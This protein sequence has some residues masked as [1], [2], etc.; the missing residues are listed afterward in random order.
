MTRMA[1]HDTK[2]QFIKQHINKKTTTGGLEFTVYISILWGATFSSITYHEIL[3]FLY[4]F[5]HL[6]PCYYLALW[7]YPTRPACLFSSIKIC[8]HTAQ[9]NIFPPWNIHQL[10]GQHYF[11]LE[12]SQLPNFRN[13]FSWTYQ[14]PEYGRV[15]TQYITVKYR[16]LILCATWPALG[17][18]DLNL[19]Q[20][21][22]S[23]QI[24][25]EPNAG[26]V[27]RFL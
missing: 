7:A 13:L 14:T 23:I 22:A 10:L 27:T 9:R 5:W 12:I 17:S 8:Q 15:N 20:S 25:P 6:K 3:D 1:G 21:A 2:S 18:D 4:I 26:H 19:D 11:S 16:G 24:L